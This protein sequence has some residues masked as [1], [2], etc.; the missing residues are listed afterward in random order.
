MAI[1]NA[2]FIYML[3]SFLFVR[4]GVHLLNT[5]RPKCFRNG[6]LVRKDLMDVQAE[7]LAVTASAVS[8]ESSALPH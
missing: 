2:E 6:K 5:L 1:G 4:I 8:P 7:R 3:L